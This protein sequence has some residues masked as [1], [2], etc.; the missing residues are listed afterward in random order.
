MKKFMLFFALLGFPFVS[1]AVVKMGACT[2]DCANEIRQF[3]REVKQ[4]QCYFLDSNSLDSDDAIVIFLANGKKDLNKSGF[5]KMVDFAG[6]YVDC[7]SSI[8]WTQLIDIKM[9]GL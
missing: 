9:G 8:V 3:V 5:N 7:E 2:V 1:N 6:I 4:S